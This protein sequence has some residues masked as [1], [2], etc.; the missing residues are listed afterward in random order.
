MQ[1]VMKNS[2]VL[3]KRI[4]ADR[5]TMAGSSANTQNPPAKRKKTVQLFVRKS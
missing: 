2:K 1:D 4:D 5:K 3:F